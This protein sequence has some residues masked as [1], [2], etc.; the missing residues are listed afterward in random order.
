MRRIFIS[1]DVEAIAQSYRDNL[2]SKHTRRDFVQPK[3]GLQDFEDEIREDQ[4]NCPLWEL[5]ADYAKDMREHFDEIILLKPSEFDTW[6]QRHFDR[7]DK[8]LLT[9]KNWRRKV[10]DISFSDHIIKI[11]HYNTVRSEDMIPCIKKLGIKTCVYCNAQYTNTI[12]IADNGSVKGRYELDH[13]W[14]KDEYPFLC[15][16]FYNLQPSCS[17]CN[18]WKRDKEAKFNLYTDNP[19]ELDPFSFELTPGSII[20]YM[21][22][23]DSNVLEIILTSTDADLLANHLE[24][25]HTEDLYETF[26]DELEELVWKYKSFNRAFKEQLI[27]RFKNLFPQHASRNEIIRFLY[28]FYSKPKDVHKRPLTKVKQDVAKQL[29]MME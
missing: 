24:R 14:A 5:Y 10:G 13:F 8:Q 26:S 19:E 7:L 3:D 2:L 25:F 15:I 4:E 16:S 21:L 27:P 12:E 20:R 18:N 29:N 1:P 22:S 9:D 11:M 28:G 6:Y 17:S 23:Q